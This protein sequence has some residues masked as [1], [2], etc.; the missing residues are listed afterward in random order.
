MNP[1]WM[2]QIS[3]KATSS[4]EANWW[5]GKV[6][7]AISEPISAAIIKTVDVESNVEC[8]LNGNGKSHDTS[9]DID[10]AASTTRDENL[11]AAALPDVPKHLCSEMDDLVDLVLKHA[12][13]DANFSQSSSKSGVAR[14]IKSMGNVTCA[15]GL[16]R[17]EV[18]Y[19]PTP[20]LWSCLACCLPSPISSDD[21]NLLPL[22]LPRPALRKF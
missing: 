1:N 13:S 14:F 19:A 17:V 20:P 21:S 15:K 18:T 3:F 11:D 10:Q 12:T 2:Y 7:Q 9:A 4:M 5:I 22:P 6:C 8:P 16:G